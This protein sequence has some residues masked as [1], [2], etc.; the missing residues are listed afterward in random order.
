MEVFDLLFLILM[1]PMAHGVDI[2]IF[3]L[4]IRNHILHP[5]ILICL[6]ILLGGFITLSTLHYYG[7]PYVVPVTLKCIFIGSHISNNKLVF[8]IQGYDKN[9]HPQGPLYL[10][11][12]TSFI[13]LSFGATPPF[14]GLTF[15]WILPFPTLVIF[16]LPM[17]LLL[18]LTV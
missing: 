11:W 5:M 17:T 18:L 13:T 12:A 6:L 1:F 8:E 14:L 7:V 2:R 10:F 4:T 9:F 16:L 3:S 15:L